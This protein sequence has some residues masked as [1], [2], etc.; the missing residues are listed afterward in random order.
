MEERTHMEREVHSA[1]QRIAELEEAKH[2][3]HCHCEVEKES[4]RNSM[5]ELSIK[6]KEAHD[7]ALAGKWE[8]T[9]AQ[10]RLVDETVQVTRL[11]DQLL[12]ASARHASV[13]LH[14]R[15]EAERATRHVR[16]PRTRR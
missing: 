9:T 11:E 2:A 14:V 5:E 4:L 8:L 13:E 7:S 10:K 12:E 16:R 3:A 6:L 15:S 1:N